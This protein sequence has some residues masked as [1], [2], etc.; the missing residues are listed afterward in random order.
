MSVPNTRTHLV[1]LEENRGKTE[2]IRGR[3]VEG[4]KYPLQ[5]VKKRNGEA[6]PQN[7]EYGNFIDLQD[8]LEHADRI[9]FNN[10]DDVKWSGS[11][12]RNNETRDMFDRVKRDQLQARIRYEEQKQRVEV[13]REWC[14]HLEERQWKIEHDTTR[15][16]A[17]DQRQ[18]EFDARR[19]QSQPVFAHSQFRGNSYNP[20]DE[21][22][23]A[24][25]LMSSLRLSRMQQDETNFQPASYPRSNGSRK[26][27][28][29]YQT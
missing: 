23:V 11:D 9:N 25:N 1:S 20:Y 24:T 6:D 27:G 17:W 14:N 5:Y 7:W 21:A 26:R 28:S 4:L 16:A 12:P 13:Q 19:A 8:L 2:I 15:R 3:P 29:E 22:D 10:L 18:R